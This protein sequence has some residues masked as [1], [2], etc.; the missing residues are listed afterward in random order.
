M[1]QSLS[2]LGSTGSIGRQTLAVAKHLGK[3]QSQVSG[4]RKRLIDRRLIE[5]DD[6]G[7]VL[8]LLPHVRGY[9]EGSERALR[10]RAIP[11]SSGTAT[12]SGGN[13]MPWHSIL[14][15]V[16]PGAAPFTKDAMFP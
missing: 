8:F 6:K 5:P 12:R 2:V 9:Y 10:E 11:D 16:Q 15:P 1:V 14:K 7:Y 3:S 13:L 4:Y